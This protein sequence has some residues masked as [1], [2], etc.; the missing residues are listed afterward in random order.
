MQREEVGE[1]KYLKA[2]NQMW[3]QRICDPGPLYIK[4]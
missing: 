4:V 1:F 3:G 2:K